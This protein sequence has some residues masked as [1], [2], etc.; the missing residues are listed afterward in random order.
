MDRVKQEISKINKKSVIQ[1]FLIAFAGF[2][3]GTL[4]TMYI[5]FKFIDDILKMMQQ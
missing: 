4:M 1:V 2:M 3:M 5:T